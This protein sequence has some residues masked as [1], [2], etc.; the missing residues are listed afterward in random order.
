MAML[1]DGARA[2]GGYLAQAALNTPWA[3]AQGTEGIGNGIRWTTGT[4]AQ[5]LQASANAVVWTVRGIG[6]S[7]EN[8]G[9]GALWTMRGLGRTVAVTTGAAAMVIGYPVAV[10]GLGAGAIA[11]FVSLFPCWAATNPPTFFDRLFNPVES[12]A[13]LADATLCPTLA[14][15]SAILISLGTLGLILGKIGQRAF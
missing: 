3:I 1:V 8:T 2:V 9:N 6:R 14:G 4:G 13:R 11:G 5:M 7:V 15:G 12:T 10:V